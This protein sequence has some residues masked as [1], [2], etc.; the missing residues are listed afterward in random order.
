ME[1]HSP[2]PRRWPSSSPATTRSSA[3]EYAGLRRVAVARAG[4]RSTPAAGATARSPAFIIKGGLEAGQAFVEAP[5]LHSHVANIGDVRSLAI[6]PASTTHSQLTDEEQLTHRRRARPGAAVGRPRVDR[7][8]PRRPRDPGSRP[9][10]LDRGLTGARPPGQPRRTSRTGHGAGC[11]ALVGRPTSSRRS[12]PRPRRAARSSAACPTRCGAAARRAARRSA[13]TLKLASVSATQACD[14]G[15]GDRL[16][17]LDLHD[18]LDLFAER[19]VRHA[20][21]RG[22]GD[23]RDARRDGSRSRRSTRSRRRG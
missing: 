8:H 10:P 1:R 7:R 13:G 23:R 21:D 16:A 4:P 17:R 6:H 15:L 2:T 3:V 9:P 20:D 18:G 12:S 22:V 14:L 19:R 11:A 5:E